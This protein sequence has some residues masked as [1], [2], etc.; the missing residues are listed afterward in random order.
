MNEKERFWLV[1]WLMNNSF[2]QIYILGSS[3]GSGNKKLRGS[4][5][6]WDNN[7]IGRPLTSYHLGA[8]NYMGMGMVDGYFE[9]WM[10][11]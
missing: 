6:N 5:I 7:T 4:L 8:L 9:T 10:R 1:Q 3:N 11:Q 2:M